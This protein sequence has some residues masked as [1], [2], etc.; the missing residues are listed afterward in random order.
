LQEFWGH[1]KAL[2]SPGFRSRKITWGSQ[3]PKAAPLPREGRSA[4]AKPQHS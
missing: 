2:F 1:R 4:L 3:K